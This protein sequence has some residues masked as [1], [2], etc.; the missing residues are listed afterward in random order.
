MNRRHE[1]EPRASGG[2]VVVS[3]SWQTLSC[4]KKNERVG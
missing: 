2:F 1:A 3:F 4:E